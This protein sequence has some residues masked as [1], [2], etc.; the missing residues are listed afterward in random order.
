MYHETLPQSYKC[1]KS[2]LSMVLHYWQQCSSLT[3]AIMLRT[4]LS[5][6]QSRQLS[7]GLH[8]TRVSTMCLTLEQMNLSY[9]FANFAT[10]KATKTFLC[11]F[12][13]TYFQKSLLNS[14]ACKFDSHMWA[15]N[16]HMMYRVFIIYFDMSGI[17]DFWFDCL[18]YE[19][20]VWFCDR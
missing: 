14:S 3:L 1:T 10:L 17:S 6:R 12:L 18:K 2:P 15:L 8:Y 7:W 4:A 13:Y 9:I 5:S 16:T 11:N 19:V 20:C